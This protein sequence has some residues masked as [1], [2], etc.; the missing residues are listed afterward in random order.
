MQ[1]H[2]NHKRR[3]VAH[4]KFEPVAQLLNHLVK[5]VEKD[6]G[7]SVV[8]EQKS[9]LQPLAQNAYT[10]RYC[11]RQPSTVRLSLTFILVGDNADRIL[12]QEDARS[13]PGTIGASSGPV[14]QRV[15]RTEKI[16]EIKRAVWEKISAHLRTSLDKR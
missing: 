15:Y 1:K 7:Q 14:D 3:A 13:D 8:L 5:D 10:V 4:A 9:P 16:E 11:L 2:A 6:H 12:L